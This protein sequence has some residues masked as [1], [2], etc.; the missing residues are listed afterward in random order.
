M[1]DLFP[2]YGQNE[3]GYKVQLQLMRLVP[4]EFIVTTNPKREIKQM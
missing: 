1:L 4:E 3:W 2:F